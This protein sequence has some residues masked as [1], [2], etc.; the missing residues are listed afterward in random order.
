MNITLRCRGSKQE[1]ARPPIC[2][3]R[4]R[5]AGYRGD[6]TNAA[7]NARVRP[8]RP[9]GYKCRDLVLA[10]LAKL[11]PHHLVA[12]RR[13]FLRFVGELG[14]HYIVVERAYSLSKVDA[15]ERKPCAQ[16]SP[17]GAIA[18]HDPQRLVQR[19]VGHW[20]AIFIG[21]PADRGSASRDRRFRRRL[22]ERMA[23]TRP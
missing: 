8:S 6:Q 4:R 15:V 19:V 11:A 9:H 2:A 17:P 7:L 16:S 21:R 5:S 23:K 10:A 12:P 3:A 14:F 20:H 18:A 13:F 1:Q 22:C